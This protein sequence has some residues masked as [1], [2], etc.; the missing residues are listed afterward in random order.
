MA[1]LSRSVYLHLY[2]LL[3]INRTSETMTDLF[4]CHISAATIQH[5]ARVSSAKLVNPEQRIKAAIRDSA[6]IGVD[7]TGLRVAGHGAYIHV[8]RTEG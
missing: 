3:P 2:Q 4:E 8:A 6:V 5:A 1:V 7:E